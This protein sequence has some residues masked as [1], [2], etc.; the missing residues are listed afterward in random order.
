MLNPF[1]AKQ[2]PARRTPCQSPGSSLTQSEALKVEFCGYLRLPELP[3]VRQRKLPCPQRRGG[4]DADKGRQ[5]SPYLFSYLV[6]VV[7][8]F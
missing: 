7:R 2:Q 3:R 8:P 5:G 6:I 4:T 1:K